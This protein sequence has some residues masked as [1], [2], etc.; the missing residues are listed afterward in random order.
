[1]FIDQVEDSEVLFQ[2]PL[3]FI[4]F[5]VEMILPSIATCLGKFIKQAFGAHKE[6]EGL[7]FPICVFLEILVYLREQHVLL[8]GP[9][10]FGL[11]FDV[12]D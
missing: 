11:E 12:K 10:W 9:N 3:R 6:L 5:W 4:N 8:F 1:M 7:S 2:G